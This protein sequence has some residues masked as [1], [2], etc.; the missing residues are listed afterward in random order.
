MKKF[1]NIV[2]C[3]FPI[4]LSS[5]TFEFE[6]IDEFA[7]SGHYGDLH[8]LLIEDNYM[9]AISHYGFEINTV[10]EDGELTRIS[11]IPIEGEVDDIEKI[12]NN[13]FVSVSSIFR[14]Q[15]EILSALYKIDVSNPYEPVVVDSIIF[16]ENIINYVLRTYGGYLAY[17]KLE[18]I[19]NEWVIT[20]LVFID[21]VTFEEILLFPVNNWTCPLRENYFLHRRN[22]IDLIFDVY[23]YTN[24]YN[25]QMVG[26]VDFATCPTDFMKIYA[27]NDDNLVLLGNESI[28]I[29]DISDLSNIQ[30]VS[31]YYRYNNASPFG[32]CIQI[33]NFLLI[34]SQSAGI[35]VVD[36]TDIGN[37]ILYDFWE[38][39]IDELSILDPYFLTLTGIIYDNG[40]LYV[41]S[42]NHG[43]LLM[44]Y[45]GGMIEYVD[46]FINNRTNKVKFLLYNNYLITSGFSRGLYVYDIENINLPELITILFEDLYVQTF[47]IINEHIHLIIQVG[48]NYYYRIYCISNI[49][50][51]I[52]IWNELLN[53]ISSLLMNENE[54]DNIYLYSYINSFQSV[55]IR[56]YDIEYPEN[57]EQILLY[58][59]SEIIFQSLFYN[60]YLYGIGI[61]ENGGSDLFIFDGFEEEEPELVNQIANFADGFQ[62]RRIKSYLNSSPYNHTGS[63]SFY[64]LDDPL[65]PEL[66]FTIQNTATGYNSYYID[67]VLFSPCRF[68]VFLYDLENDPTGELEPFDYFN[69]NSDYRGISFFSQ[70]EDDYF[71]CEQ[72]ECIS[73]YSYILETSA[74][75]ELPKLEVTLSNYPNP[76]NPET[77][78]QFNLPE[79]GNVKLEI[80]NIKGQLVKTLLDCYMSPGHSEMIWNGR[81]DNGKRVSSGVYLYQLQ[82]PGKSFT[83]KCMLLK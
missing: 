11:V 21:P 5:L 43:I 70:G 40:H 28:S 38:Y 82:T 24:I 80:Y 30:I 19:D 69:L 41:G 68:T 46:N 39:P 66:A 8:R 34:P 59:F 52:Q 44:N 25:I 9:Y 10:D 78:I 23:D 67:N 16:P 13:V 15:G 65:N 54:P 75:D 53:G 76:F 81:E 45:Q 57:I 18:E 74:E 6:K 37:P 36:I 42:Y 29:Y 77:T 32:D 63:D 58:E 2:L 73:T 71:F 47:E 22:Y 3:F 31:T 56:K 26:S 35:E 12:G 20:Q 49:S 64:N 14:W 50:N 62:I 79:E 17:H 4:I 1:L 33:D 72:L 60:G 48:L 83:K 7:V 55:E 51:P 61:F 27:I